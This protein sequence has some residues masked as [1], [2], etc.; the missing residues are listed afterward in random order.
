MVCNPQ[1]D[2]LGAVSTSGERQ[3]QYTARRHNNSDNDASMRITFNATASFQQ[4]PS[5]VE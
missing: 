1:W 4:C 5:T 3:G 2:I